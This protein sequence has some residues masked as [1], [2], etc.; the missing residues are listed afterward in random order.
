[1]KPLC[2]D[3]GNVLGPVRFEEFVTTLSVSANITESEAQERINLY[4]GFHDTGLI[5]MKQI[6]IKEFGL[7]SE[8][9]RFQVMTQW[10][11]IF[12]IDSGVIDFFENLAAN[13]PD[14]K[15]ALLS[16]VGREHS[17]MLDDE[18]LLQS[19]LFLSAVKH[20]SCRVGTRKPNKLYYHSFLQ[21]HPQFKGAVYVDDNKDNLDSA[22]EFGFVTVNLDLLTMEKHKVEEKLNLIERLVKNG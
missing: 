16:N 12:N 8:F 2:L 9:L 15:L 5:T 14:F 19:N 3:I 18:P 4:Q 22:R 7:K 1:M 6:L 13:N 10:V 20:Y 21:M 17:L 11:D